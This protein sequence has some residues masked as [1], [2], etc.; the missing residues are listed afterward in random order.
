[1]PKKITAL[2]LR[3]ST[4]DQKTGLESQRKA[5]T[6]YAENH[7]IANIQ[8]YADKMTGATTNRPQFN[9]LQEDIFNGKVGCVIV[10]KLDRLSRSLQDGVNVLTD[11]IE[12]GVRVVSIT[13]QLDFAGKM[14][15]VMLGL[16]FALAEMERANIRE[17]ILR[18]QAAARARG[19]T[20]GGSKKGRHYKLTPEK[21]RAIGKLLAENYS[22]AEIARI[23]GISR[24]TLYAFIQVLRR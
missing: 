15:K 22:K 6:E 13:Q 3:V 19:K 5:L 17:N 24:T 16:L 1:M 18:G 7:G 9:Q 10:W 2:Y 11:W 23:V 12:R 8:I 4:F 14:G 20:W 21:Q